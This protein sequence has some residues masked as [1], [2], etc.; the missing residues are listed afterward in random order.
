L[1]RG[2][3]APAPPQAHGPCHGWSGWF[4]Q[5]RRCPRAEGT[6]WTRSI[7]VID[8]ARMVDHWASPSH[9][10]G[11]P[12][13][14]RAGRRG[15]RASAAD[16]LKHVPCEEKDR[17]GDYAGGSELGGPGLLW[18]HVSTCTL[19]VSTSAIDH[20]SVRSSHQR[21]GFGTLAALPIFPI[22][23]A[24]EECDAEEEKMD[25]RRGREAQVHGRK[26]FARSD[27]LGTGTASRIGFDKGPRAENIPGFSPASAKARQRRPRS[28]RY[29]P[30]RLM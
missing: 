12:L 10:P 13:I 18:G 2:H 22:A 30:H 25:R 8:R 19:L 26:A 21:Q 20:R 15:F 24:K 16:A 28:G 9:Q 23:H 6:S 27:R 4:S 17:D 1:Q 5:T 7:A 11:S 14:C 29:G 3:G